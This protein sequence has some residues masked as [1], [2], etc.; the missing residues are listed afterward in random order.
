METHAF[1]KFA[2]WMARQAGKAS[3]FV[4]ALALLVVWAVTGPLFGW[5]DTWQLII[6]TG[7]TI[8]TFLMVFL[9][10]NTQ[11]RDTEAL[12]LKLDELIRATKGARHSAM[13]LEDKSEEQLD[14]AQ[15][16]AAE[17]AAG[18][19][20]PAQQGQGAPGS[21]AG[22]R[23][24]R[25]AGAILKEPSPRSVRARHRKAL[26][27]KPRL[28]HNYCAAGRGNGV[29]GTAPAAGLH[30][31]QPRLEDHAARV[32]ALANRLRGD[33]IEAIIDQYITS[34]PE[35]WPRWMDSHVRDDDFVVMV[36]TETYYRRVIGK[37]KPGRRP[38]RALGGEPHLQSSLR[39]RSDPLR[40]GSDG[41]R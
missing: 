11:N 41:C 16:R 25:K 39:K 15:G 32:L 1:A 20:T 8:I 10:Q 9:I 12:H 18:A 27:D 28:R 19:A 23:A 24:T 7:T 3:T 22:R 13:E 29:D 5:S 35:G 30:Q 31:L 17:E 38:R 2:H 36:C 14:A 34:P 37:E 26:G 33:G 6:N 21:R 40:S 4:A